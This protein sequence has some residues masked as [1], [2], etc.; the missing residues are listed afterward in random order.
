M[1]KLNSD[2]PGTTDL[3][4][5]NDDMF[6][7]DTSRYFNAG[8]SALANIILAM[9]IANKDA[10]ESILDI[11]CG[12]GR[13]LR[14]I[15]AKFPYAD[16]TACDLNREAVDFCVST[17]GVNGIYSEKNLETLRLN[18]KFD[19]IWC[20]SLL[21][22]LDAPLWR[23]F[24]KFFS[25]HLNKEGILALTTHGQVSAQ[26]LHENHYDYG[27]DKNEIPTILDRYNATGFG[28]LNYPNVPD[29]G[30]SIA[31]RAW[32]LAEFQRHAGLKLLSFVEAGWDD[33]QD[34]VA[35]IRMAG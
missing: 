16:V 27:L 12:Y 14:Y 20:G 13:V 28:Y 4:A 31:S 7:G 5:A 33:H 30:V 17:F 26:W 10:C 21:T 34:V 24:I 9:N 22:H 11:P 29:Y 6:A 32:V 25:D 15:R 35:C 8:R 1:S 19:L 18:Q 3:I 2:V 23:A